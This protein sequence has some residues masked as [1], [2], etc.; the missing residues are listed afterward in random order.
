MMPSVS[1]YHCP[2]LPHQFE[3]GKAFSQGLGKHGIKADVK[4]YGEESDKDLAVFW[5]HG[6]R[7]AEIRKQQLA[8]GRHYLVMERGYFGDRFLHCSLGFDGLNGQASFLSHSSTSARWLPHSHLLKPWT[9]EGNYYLLVGQVAGDNSCN[10]VNLK[11]WYDEVVADSHKPVVFRPH[12]YDRS[13]YC[14]EGALLSVR[15]LTQDLTHAEAVIT[16]S[17]TVG[18]DSLMAGKPT[19]AYDPI[20]MVYSVTGHHVSEVSD[21]EPPREQWAHDL[22]YTQWSKDEI[23]SGEAWDHLRGMYAD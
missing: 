14:P 8:K 23:E 19:V 4:A 10:H 17:S 21:I 1:I 15:S 16:F 3:W 22:A 9:P 5:G 13:G 7:N 20:S 11:D 2:N 18:V 12:P 6:I